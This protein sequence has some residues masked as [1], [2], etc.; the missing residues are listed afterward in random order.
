[1]K[2][3]RVV[4]MK[5]EKFSIGKQNGPLVM[6]EQI[7]NVTTK[8]NKIDIPCPLGMQLMTVTELLPDITISGDEK[9]N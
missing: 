5:I 3:F 6:T 2:K 8:D 7:I 9:K 1:M 4:C